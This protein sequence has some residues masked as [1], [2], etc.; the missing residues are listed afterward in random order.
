MLLVPKT[1]FSADKF[2]YYTVGDHKTYSK[3]EAI[4]LQ[5]RTGHFP[6]WNF[7]ENVFSTVNWTREPDIDLWEL[8][9]ARARQIRENYDYVVLW[10]SGG[11]DSHNMVSSWLD[12]GCKIDE[13]A[14]FWN[15]EG[16]RDRNDLMN[17]E[18]QKVVFDKIKLL[19]ERN[20]FNF[21]F[22]N[23]IH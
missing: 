14:T 18:P 9:K 10:Y 13:I 11:S 8:Y 22:S 7:N 6:E 2:G 12:A 4:E 5:K 19:Q 3:L 20:D 1:T 16:S 23:I 15:Y 21:R 17:A